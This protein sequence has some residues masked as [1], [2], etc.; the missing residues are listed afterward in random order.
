MQGLWIL[1]P[2][3]KENTIKSHKLSFGGI[4]VWDFR[5]TK[6]L[7]DFFRVHKHF[8]F[9]S[10]GFEKG[11]PTKGK[12]TINFDPFWSIA[13]T[14]TLTPPSLRI[15][16]L[17]RIVLGTTC[18]LTWHV[19]AQAV[20]CLVTVGD[21]NHQTKHNLSSYTGSQNSSVGLQVW[22]PG[23]GESGRLEEYINKRELVIYVLDRRL[24][25]P[26]R[27]SRTL[28]TRTPSQWLIAS[29]KPKKER[30]S[31]TRRTRTGPRFK[32]TFQAAQALSERALTILS[33]L[34]GEDLT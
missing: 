34:G 22:T 5:V 27:V 16:L 12:N 19:T 33:F 7:W 20:T 18:G 14:V 17:S 30:K 26:A 2:V 23:P 24:D 25:I 28:Q 31:Q 8:L 6:F 10:H 13:M 21:T 9:P 15:L 29:L 11:C 3:I 32:V 4:K 1:F